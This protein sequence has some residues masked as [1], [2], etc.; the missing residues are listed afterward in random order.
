MWL[1]MDHRHIPTCSSSRSVL[2]TVRGHSLLMP[3]CSALTAYHPLQSFTTDGSHVS[4]SV[5]T[6]KRNCIIPHK[7]MYFYLKERP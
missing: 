4:S 3:S 2:C 5:L 7:G 1:H 6:Y